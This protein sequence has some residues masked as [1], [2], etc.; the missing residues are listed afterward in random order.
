MSDSF[1][2]TEE[3]QPLRDSSRKRKKRV[4]LDSNGI[5]TNILSGLLA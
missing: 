4:D 3:T 5:S 1:D 2:N